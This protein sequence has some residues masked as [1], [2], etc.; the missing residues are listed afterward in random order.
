MEIRT[1]PFHWDFSGGIPAPFSI[2]QL[3]RRCRICHST[4]ESLAQAIGASEPRS[5]P[6]WRLVYR[7][8]YTP[9]QLQ[10]WLPL[11]TRRVFGRE[12]LRSVLSR[13]RKQPQECVKPVVQL[14]ET[15]LS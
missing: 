1:H 8:H 10:P 6:R 15:Q 7:G 12:A 14:T 13:A 9:I 11:A 3:S 4:A 5:T 2:V